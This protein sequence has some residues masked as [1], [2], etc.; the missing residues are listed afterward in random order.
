M[1]AL[2]TAIKTQLQSDLTYVRASDIFVTE[3]ES[4]IPE[5]VKS[6][7]VGLKDGPVIRKELAGRMMEYN[8]TV[9]IVLYVQLLRPEAAIIGDGTQKGILDMEADVHTALDENLLGVAGMQSAVAAPDQPESELFGDETNAFQRKI[10]T[11]EY[12]KEEARP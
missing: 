6:Q 5:T 8:M 3:D 12:I 1:K 2:L 10:I 7:A 4:L 11:Y 9:K